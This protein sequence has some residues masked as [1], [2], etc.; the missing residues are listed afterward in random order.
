MYSGKAPNQEEKTSSKPH[1]RIEQ[2]AENIVDARAQCS[3]D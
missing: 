1:N 3:G 2:V